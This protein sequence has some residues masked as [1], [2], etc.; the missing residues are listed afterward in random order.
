MVSD[1]VNQRSILKITNPDRRQSLVICCKRSQEISDCKGDLRSC[2]VIQ[3]K[4]LKAGKEICFIWPA[5]SIFGPNKFFDIG[6]GFDQ[7]MLAER[8]CSDGGDHWLQS[9][10]AVVCGCEETDS[11]RDQRCIL[12][13][14]LRTGD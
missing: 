8:N 2:D 3:L 14:C 12:R 1:R 6:S 5:I 9:S 11:A 4:I 10:D 7:E 13:P